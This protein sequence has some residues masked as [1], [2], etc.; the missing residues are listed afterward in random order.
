MKKI[1]TLFMVVATL[2]FMVVCPAFGSINIF[3]SPHD[4]DTVSFKA[5]GI[6]GGN[7][8]GPFLGTLN[9]SSQWYTFCVESDGHVEYF[10]ENVPY[11]VLNTSLNTATGSGNIVTNAAKWLYWMYGTDWSAFSVGGYNY[12]DTFDDKTSLQLAIWHGVENPTGTP[13]AISAY[14]TDLQA[15]K[16]FATATA[17]VSD[18]NNLPSFLN[19]VRVMNP[20]YYSGTT[21][22]QSMLYAIPEPASIIVWSLIATVCW[23]GVT[24]WRRRARV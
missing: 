8:G 1:T 2:L 6:S 11:K 19:A 21:Q 24:A 3:I 17:A 5:S 20:G 12:T 9:N 18:P 23:L 15:K 13:L 7:S 22:A 14:N 4:L 10:A 16:W